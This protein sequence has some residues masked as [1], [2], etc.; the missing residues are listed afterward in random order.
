MAQV[1]QLDQQ[2]EQLAV[3]IKYLKLKR[4]NDLNEKLRS[5]LSRERITA[6]NACLSLINFTTNNTDYTLPDVWG[7]LEPGKNHFRETVRLRR[8]NRPSASADSTGCCTIV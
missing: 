1:L 2:Q 3:R 7:H 4:I 5:E 8:A 6:S